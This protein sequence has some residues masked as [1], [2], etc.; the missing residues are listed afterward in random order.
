MQALDGPR[1]A[2]IGN[3]HP[4]VYSLKRSLSYLNQSSHGVVFSSMETRMMEV[5][6]AVASESRSSTCLVITQ[7]QTFSAGLNPHLWTV[8]T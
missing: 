2:T 3:E 8:M 4:L 7:P 5:Q 6:V 1:V